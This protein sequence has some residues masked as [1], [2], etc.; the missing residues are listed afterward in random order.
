MNIFTN[1]KIT[2]TID[3]IKECENNGFFSQ[4]IIMA[5]GGFKSKLASSSTNNFI[6]TIKLNAIIS[7]SVSVP[8]IILY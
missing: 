1:L 2:Q 6:S 5:E 3:C 4:Q 8:L 7:V